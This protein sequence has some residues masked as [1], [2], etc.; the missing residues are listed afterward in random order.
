MR[1][2]L[3]AILPLFALACATPAAAQLGFPGG[4]S[5]S[6][7][8]IVEETGPA[9]EE[10]GDETGQPAGAAPGQVPGQMPQ[11]PQ[12]TWLLGTGGRAGD[13]AS[14]FSAFGGFSRPGRVSMEGALSYARSI[15]DGLDGINVLGGSLELGLF[16][17]QLETLGL[18]LAVNGEAQWVEEVAQGYAVGAALSKTFVKRLE[19]GGRVAYSGSDPEAGASTWAWV[20][21]LT[22]AI[23]PIRNT[24]VRANYT[25]DNDLDTEDS[26]ELVAAHRVHLGGSPPFQVRVGINKNSDISAGLIV[27]LGPR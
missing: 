23:F 27:F 4:I 8:P 20:P 6:P 11:P 10:T 15:P 17:A 19:V 26:Y 5:D 18:V 1:I 12:V 13:E 24:S 14:V 3:R 9:D 2:T 7:R 21:G 16:G 25:F 22:A